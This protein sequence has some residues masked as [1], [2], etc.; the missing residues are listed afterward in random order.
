MSRQKERSKT[1]LANKADRT[2]NSEGLEQNI[3]YHILYQAILSVT[4]MLPRVQSIMFF[5]QITVAWT[6]KL[7]TAQ[8]CSFYTKT[9][10]TY[11]WSNHKG[12]SNSMLC[13]AW[14]SLFCLTRSV[15]GHFFQTMFNYFTLVISNHPWWECLHPKNWQM[16]QTSYIK[17]VIKVLISTPLTTWNLCFSFPVPPVLFSP[18]AIFT[19][20]ITSALTH[21][22]SAYCS[23]AIS[24]E[25][26]QRHWNL[27]QEDPSFLDS[28][29]SHSQVLLVS[30]SSKIFYIKNFMSL[31]PPNHKDLHHI[32]VA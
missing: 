12:H 17:S 24:L 9:F 3:S 2:W 13:R 20:W 30:G 7:F 8:T 22:K 32:L 28:Y 1:Y 31:Y 25:F 4:E 29:S 16:L 6:P 5:G 21:P 18:P 23:Q 14:A 10:T 27:G 15:C 19:N 11:V 26:S